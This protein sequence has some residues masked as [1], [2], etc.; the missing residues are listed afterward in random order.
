MAVA[1]TLAPDLAALLPAMETTGRLDRLRGAMATDEAPVEGLLV[2]SLTNIRY[3]TGFV[4][5]AGLLLVSEASTTLITDGRYATQA[6]EQMHAAGVTAVIEIAKAV[7]QPKVVQAAVARAGIGRLGLEAAHVTWAAKHRYATEWLP[8]V[9]LV[10]TVGLVEGLRRRKDAGEVARIA[11]AAAVA[12]AAL[13]RIRPMLGD[14]PA[15]TDVA[16]ELD[17]TMRRLGATR[18]SFET[19]VAGGPNAAKPHH[20]PS[21][22]PIGRGEAVIMDFGALVDGY[23]SD[24]TRTI[25]VDELSSAE[26]RRAVAV[27]GAAQAAGVAA[28]AAGVEGVEVDRACRDVIVEAGWGEQFV[29]G[30]GHGVGLDV[31]EAP[32]VASTSTDTLAAGHVVTVEPGVYLPGIGGVRIEDTVVVTEHGC[33]L[34]TLTP[35][36][37]C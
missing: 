26:L 4:G 11:R 19:I 1:P 9:E 34:L 13:A 15:E 27:V 18:A 33:K 21:P 6:D 23:A 37:L 28:V 32:S 35:K 30:T 24:M 22:R 14:G 36:D 17:A 3:L 31:H 7:D 5:S 2:T 20:R 12:D 25:W 29:H 16:L 8:D 10:A